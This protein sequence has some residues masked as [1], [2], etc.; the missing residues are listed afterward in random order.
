MTFIQMVHYSNIK[1][2]IS[3]LGL[4]LIFSF[5][6]RTWMVNT[7]RF[8]LFNDVIDVNSKNSYYAIVKPITEWRNDNEINILY[9]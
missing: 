3:S 4:E 1:L 9:L 7:A 8:F 5:S 2:N 6:S